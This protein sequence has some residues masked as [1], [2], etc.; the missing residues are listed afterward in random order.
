MKKNEKMLI[1]LNHKFGKLKHA[2]DVRRLQFK[3]SNTDLSP[4]WCEK[5]MLIKWVSRFYSVVN[6]IVVHFQS[7]LGMR[8]K[9]S[10]Y[11]L[12]S[13]YHHKWE[14][15]KSF[16]SVTLY[17]VIIFMCTVRNFGLNRRLSSVNFKL[18]YFYGKLNQ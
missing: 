9:E 2:K 1:I 3:Y 8:K 7:K 4:F 11:P 16:H 6:N 10:P 15:F 14:N 17:W 5:I 12:G 18:K 13:F